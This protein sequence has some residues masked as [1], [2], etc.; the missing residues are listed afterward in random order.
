MASGKLVRT[1][2]AALVAGLLAAIACNN[3]IAGGPSG[4]PFPFSGPSCSGAD[5]DQNCWDCVDVEGGPAGCITSQCSA[6]FTCFCACGAADTKCQDGCTP[7][8]A[9]TTCLDA[10]VHYEALNC[11]SLC[12]GA[13]ATLDGGDAASE[14][15]D[16][17]REGGDA[18]GDGA[19][20][21]DSGAA[22]D[23]PRE[24]E[25]SADGARD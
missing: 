8:P 5:L 14:G 10:V 13:A 17:A 12:P 4:P 24:A 2:W 3:G 6:Y 25:A 9:C 18:A 15:G 1:A 7:T 11:G 21:G 16:A 22:G 20:A 23:G 19:G